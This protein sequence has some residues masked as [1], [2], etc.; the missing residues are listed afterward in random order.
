VTYYK[1]IRKQSLEPKCFF[2]SFFLQSLGPN[3]F[4]PHP[5]GDDTFVALTGEFVKDKKI[6]GKKN[7]K[8]IKGIKRLKR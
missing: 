1:L 7:D 8:K 5:G 2:F 6:K 4:Y 3:C